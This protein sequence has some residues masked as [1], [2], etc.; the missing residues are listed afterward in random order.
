MENVITVILVGK[1]FLMKSGIE[2]FLSEFSS[3]VVAASFDGTEPGLDTKFQTLKPDIVII[4]PIEPFIEM[5]PLLL[6]LSKG[7]GT[8]IIAVTDVDMPNEIRGKFNEVISTDVDKMELTKVINK[9]LVE[10]GLKSKPEEVDHRLSER[11]TDI[12]KHVAFGYTNQEIADK[13]FLSIHTVTTHRKNITR[14]LGIK[15]V[16]GLTVYALMNKLILPSQVEKQS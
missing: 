5:K 8:S 4:N 16:S 14:K 13:L 6:S 10:K 7:Q 2:A 1:S 3:V 15:T 12:L 9:V 11:E